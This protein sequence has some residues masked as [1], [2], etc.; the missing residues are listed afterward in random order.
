MFIFNIFHPIIELIKSIVGG[1]SKY[2]KDMPQS[3][4]PMQIK[5]EG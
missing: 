3:S 2:P 1:T 5:K 4:K